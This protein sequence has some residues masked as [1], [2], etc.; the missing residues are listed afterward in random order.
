MIHPPRTSEAFLLKEPSAF[1]RGF[2][3]YARSLVLVRDVL[4]EGHNRE[5]EGDHDQD[6]DERHREG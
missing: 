3:R 4:P 5:R 6:L 2:S 1:G